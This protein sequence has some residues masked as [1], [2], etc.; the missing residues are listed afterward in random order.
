MTIAKLSTVAPLLA[1][2]GLVLVAEVNEQKITSAEID[3]ARGYL[4]EAELGVIGATRGMSDAQWKFKPAPDRW[5]AAEIVEHMVLV[6]ELILGPV[7][8]QLAQAPA[9][10]QRNTKLI[11]SA[12][13]TQLPDRSSKFQAPDVLKPTGRW[14]PSEALVRLKENDA[15]LVAYLETTPDVRQHAIEALPLKA[16][17]KGAYDQMDGYQWVLG[18]AA[19]TERHTKQLLEVKADPNFPA[20]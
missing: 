2:G 19:H 3:H 8:T 18:S 10:G 14:T 5:S 11:D 1:A 4:R 17:T 12:V 16:V 9:P 6:Q 20:Q 15:K 13:Q 7:R